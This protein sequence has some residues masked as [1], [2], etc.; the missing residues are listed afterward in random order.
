MPSDI[1]AVG[2]I[3]AFRQAVKTH[4]FR[5]AFINGF[6]LY[7]SYLRDYWNAPLSNL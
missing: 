3:K 1:L 5:L 4:Y 6:V 2:D 7:I